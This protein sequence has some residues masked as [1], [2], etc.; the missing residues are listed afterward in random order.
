MY[1]AAGSPRE[2]FALKPVFKQAI[3]LL[4]PRTDIKVLKYAPACLDPYQTVISVRGTDP[5]RQ[6]HCSLSR[7]HTNL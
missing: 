2:D 3:L 6:K 7:G 4:L 5:G 1:I